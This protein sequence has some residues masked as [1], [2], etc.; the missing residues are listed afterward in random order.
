MLDDIW[1]EGEVSETVELKRRQ[2]KKG[3]VD[4]VS[5]GQTASLQQGFDSGY[6]TGADLGTRV[7]RILAILKARGDEDS[8][9]QAIKELGI[10]DVLK[11]TYFDGDLKV[12]DGHLLIEHWEKI[13][14]IT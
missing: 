9:K 4:G 8:Y 12:K 5:Q 6:P 14:K 7:G 10:S 11:S 3:Y 2:H 1:G 13:V